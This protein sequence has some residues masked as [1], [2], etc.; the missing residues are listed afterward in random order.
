MKK[1]VLLFCI[2][3]SGS[4]M[5]FAQ[6]EKPRDPNFTNYYKDVA[7]ITTDAITISF[8]DVVAKSGYCKLKVRIK[9]NTNDYILFKTNEC[10]FILPQG[11]YQCNERLKKSNSAL[12]KSLHAIDI[13]S[14]GIILIPPLESGYRVLDIKGDGEYLVESFTLQLKGLYR[15]SATDEVLSAPNFNLPA[16]ANTFT[17]GPFQCTLT[18]TKKETKETW[19]RF[20]CTYTG[21]EAG[22]IDPNKT[23]VRIENGQEFANGKSHLKQNVLLKGETDKFTLFF[24]VPASVVDMQFANMQIVWKN[25]FLDSKISPLTSHKVTF[26]ID[27]GKTQGK[28]KR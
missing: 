4:F 12:D 2:I 19:T 18:G 27:P 15:F 10:S 26:V 9:N 14:D 13:R 22:I 6:R 11:E 17:T 3:I 20:E 5:L 23:V 28:N 1:F 8:E 25:T 24:Y 16:S 7:P 21:D